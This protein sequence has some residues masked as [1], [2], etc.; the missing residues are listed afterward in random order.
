MI[1][2]ANKNTSAECLFIKFLKF[3]IMKLPERN[4][5]FNIAKGNIRNK[6][7]PHQ[8]LFISIKNPHIKFINEGRALRDR[9]KFN[10]LIL[11]MKEFLKQ[12]KEGTVEQYFL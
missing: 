7:R 6:K 8:S 5:D 2:R 10:T 1:K 3:L 9:N 11:K 4:L 12:A